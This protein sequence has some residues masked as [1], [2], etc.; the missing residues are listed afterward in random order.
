MR[1]DAGNRTYFVSD[2]R[3][4]QFATLTPAE[5]MAWIEQCSQ[6]IR[7]ARLGWPTEGKPQ[8]ESQKTS[9]EDTSIR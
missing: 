6:F 4:R 5:K 7:L 8:N 1:P 2:E 9:G 3:L